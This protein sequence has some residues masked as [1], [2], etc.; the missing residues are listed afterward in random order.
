MSASKDRSAK[1]YKDSKETF[2]WVDIP[3]VLE[4]IEDM[5]GEK[6][7]LLARKAR[8]LYPHLLQA[9]GKYLETPV[10]FKYRAGKIAFYRLAFSNI[11]S[12]EKIAKL[13]KRDGDLD[14]A[15]KNLEKFSETIGEKLAGL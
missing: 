3:K 8:E 14:A 10:C 9:F 1:S 2:F 15:S 11:N 6:L 12:F 4:R 5:D 13:L 7:E